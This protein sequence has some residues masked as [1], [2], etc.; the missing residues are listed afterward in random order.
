MRAK[1]HKTGSAARRHEARARGPP[2]L[3][4]GRR[5]ARR[6]RGDPSIV[7]PCLDRGCTR[8]LLSPL[9]PRATSRARE[10]EHR[11]RS[12]VKACDTVS[13]VLV[14]ARV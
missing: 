7:P 3:G 14:H 11:M 8:L 1:A 4:E 13:Q 12:A 2:S 10:A 9:T 6:A 5:R